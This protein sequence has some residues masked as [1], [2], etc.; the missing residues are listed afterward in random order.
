MKD[1]LDLRGHQICPGE[2]HLLRRLIKS[3]I[4]GSL[5]LTGLIEHQ[6]LQT[7]KGHLAQQD[8]LLADPT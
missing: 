6:S 5:S 4:Q 7:L 8:Q 2:H 1:L 3:L